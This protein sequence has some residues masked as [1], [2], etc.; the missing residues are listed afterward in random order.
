M[1]AVF[2]CQ[3]V[4]AFQRSGDRFA[5]RKR[6]KSRIRTPFDSIETGLQH[7][8]AVKRWMSA[9]DDQAL[10]GHDHP[11]AIL[12]A[13]GVDPAEAR[14]GIA[15]IHLIHASPAFDQRA[16]IATSRSTQPSTVGSLPTSAWA[17]RS[18]PQA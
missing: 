13:D 15:G 18:A 8:V 10:A 14:D 2:P 17:Q 1:P 5:S 11:A 7:H 3:E 16:A 12:A 9:R 4:R 6:V